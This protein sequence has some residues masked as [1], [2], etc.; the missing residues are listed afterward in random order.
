[1]YYVDFDTFISLIV[2]NTFLDDLL[3]KYREEEKKK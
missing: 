3:K 2:Q 1:M